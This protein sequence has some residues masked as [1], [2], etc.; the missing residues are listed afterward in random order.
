MNICAH[1]TQN[2][3]TLGAPATVAAAGQGFKNHVITDLETGCAWA[4]GSYDA[5]SWPPAIG[6]GHR[7]KTGGDS[8]V[9]MTEPR[10]G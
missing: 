10:G 3:R 8:I 2:L 9:R 1:I 4:H 7:R 6:Y 5:A